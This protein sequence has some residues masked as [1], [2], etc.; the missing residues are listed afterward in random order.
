[1][2]FKISIESGKVPVELTR[3]LVKANFVVQR[4]QSLAS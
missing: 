3:R 4:S 1:M 2:D